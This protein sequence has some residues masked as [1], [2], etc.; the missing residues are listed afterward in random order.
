MNRAF[1]MHVLAR[2]QTLGNVSYVALMLVF[3]TSQLRERKSRSVLQLV[4]LWSVKSD[5]DIR[6][7]GPAKSVLFGDI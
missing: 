6:V 7:T 2:Y 3:P 5:L 1:V 4:V